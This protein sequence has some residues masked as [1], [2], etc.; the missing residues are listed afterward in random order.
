VVLYKNRK[1]GISLIGDYHNVE[2]IL[3]VTMSNELELD[4]V[5]D[6][7]AVILCDQCAMIPARQLEIEAL[8]ESKAYAV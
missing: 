5:K 1:D 2:R 7:G 8:D 4:I 6:D 3:F